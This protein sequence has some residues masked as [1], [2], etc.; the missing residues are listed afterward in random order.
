MRSSRGKDPDPSRSPPR[1]AGRN[2]GIE[3]KAQGGAWQ[4]AVE[5]GGGGGLGGGK[6]EADRRMLVRLIA[7]EPHDWRGLLVVTQCLWIFDGCINQ[8]R[9][10]RCRRRREEGHHLAHW[11]RKVADTVDVAVVKNIHCH[12]SASY[13]HHVSQ[14]V[15]PGRP[16]TPPFAVRNS[17]RVA[18]LWMCATSS[19]VRPP[20]S[21]IP[22]SN[23]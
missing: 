19:G 8:E 7:A 1:R 9:W 15:T 3:R 18:S 16:R 2:R 4:R 20:S 11:Q 17:I 23:C 21:E 6:E 12:C 13:R 5:S 14:R 10:Q 22:D